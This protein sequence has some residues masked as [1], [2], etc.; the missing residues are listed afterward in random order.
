MKIH[1]LLLVLLLFGADLYSQ[2]DKLYLKDGRIVKCEIVSQDSLR[3]FFNTYLQDEKI[4]TSIQKSK[5]ERVVVYE[6]MSRPIMK[7]SALNVGVG[8]GPSYGILGAQLVY[9]KNNSGLL[10][11]LG[12]T[13]KGSIAPAIGVQLGINWFFANVGIGPHGEYS[14]DDEPFELA[15]GVFY[16]IGGMINLERTKRWYLGIGFG[17]AVRDDIEGNYRSIETFSY[18]GSLGIGCRF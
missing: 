14:L 2:K 12:A 6:K 3:Y 15:Q 4:S 8:Y 10:L 1:F 9:G 18:S 16:N 5:V 13:P 7:S 11:G 17:G